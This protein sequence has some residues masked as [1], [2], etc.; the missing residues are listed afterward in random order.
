MREWDRRLCCQIG[1]EVFPVDTVGQRRIVAAALRDRRH[2]R[3][4][5]Y[6]SGKRTGVFA[7]VFLY[8]D[9]FA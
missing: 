3:A 4:K 9:D 7:G 1:P 8:A 6:V 2:S 5:V